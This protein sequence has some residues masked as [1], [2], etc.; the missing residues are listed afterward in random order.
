MSGNFLLDWAILAVSLF[1]TILMFWL[2]LTVLLNAERRNW[3]VWATGGSLL[4]GGV[5]FISH[6]AILGLNTYLTGYGINFWWHVGWLPVAALPCSWYVVILWYSGFWDDAQTALRRRQ[7]PWLVIIGLGTAGLIGL[8][9]FGNPLP[10][11]AQMAQFQLSATPGLG[12][13]PLLLLVYPLIIVASIGLSIDALLRPGPSRRVMGT[14]AR[15]RAR[16]WL[17]AAAIAFL[18]VSLLVSGVLAWIV[19]STRSRPLDGFYAEATLI[20][21]L[22]DGAIASLIATALLLV[23]Q[24]VVAYEVF[25]GKALP[26]HGLQRAWRSAIFL[27]AGYSMVV[28]W[29]LTIGLR[30]IYSLLLTA[31]LMTVFLALS[32]WR[33][34]VERE[35]YMRGLRPF[36]ASQH[37]Y[38][39]ILQP[40]ASPGL[41]SGADMSAPFRALCD[42]V[43]GTRQACLVAV[44]ALAPLVD[45]PLTFPPASPVPRISL[46]ALW[47][48]AGAS[49][50]WPAHDAVPLDPAVYGGLL[51]AVPLWSERGLIGFL[52]LGEKRDGGLY[53]QEEIELARASGERLLDTRASAELARRLMLL[54]RQRLAE[55]QVLDRRARRV[56][57]DDV[58]PRLHTALLL[59][60]AAS[61]AAEAAPLLTEAHHQIAELLRELPS[62]SAPEVTRLGLFGAL[63]QTVADE[64]GGAFD[65]VIWHIDE[66]AVRQAQAIPPLTTEVLFYAAREAI[67]NA[68]KHG[69]GADPEVQLRLRIAGS[70]QAGLKITI[71]DNGVGWGGGGGESPGGESP[72]GESPDR[73]T[74]GGSG[75]GLALHSTLLAVVGGTLA[76]ESAP[77]A[78]TRILINLPQAELL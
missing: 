33:S 47:P 57:H 23:G 31:V 21:S 28:S 22:F 72:G 62:A 55:S 24:A 9:L 66:A 3:G 35:R 45:P 19:L 71:E 2:G 60:S 18:L 73:E 13:V 42:E 56:L 77:G 67:R 36:V 74:P 17:V 38:P 14:L 70:W 58:L 26:R 75:Q 4:L 50:T 29:S 46:A 40:A 27:A 12:G 64:W 1:N 59:V 51:W 44:G 53:S 76:V 25:T 32:A 65:E 16:P 5:F 78:F 68:A 49:E 11:V 61:P 34:Y 37:L 30:P 8:L 20:L 48:A 63:R 7:T 41:P 54:Q 15:R 52:L 69:R 39:S 43:L 6:S 10:S